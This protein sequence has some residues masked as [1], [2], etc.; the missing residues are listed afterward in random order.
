MTAGTQLLG[1]DAPAGA[2]L[3]AQVLEVVV[4]VQLHV[5]ELYLFHLRLIHDLLRLLRNIR[6][7]PIVHGILSSRRPLV[8]DFQEALNIRLLAAGRLALLVNLLVGVDAVEVEIFLHLMHILVVE[9][10]LIKDAGVVLI[11]GSAVHLLLLQH[12]R[13]SLRKPH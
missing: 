3:L 12:R 10:V 8:G 2:I 1:L 9:N 4:C 6:Y 5:R 11:L 13:R 7:L